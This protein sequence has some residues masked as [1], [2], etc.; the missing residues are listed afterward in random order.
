[1]QQATIYSTKKAEHTGISGPTTERANQP[2][3]LCRFTATANY[4]RKLET[5]TRTASDIYIYI[6]IYMY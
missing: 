2:L 5:G 6:Y 1:M 4:S 3:I